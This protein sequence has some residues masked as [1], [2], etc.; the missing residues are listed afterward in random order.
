MANVNP[1]VQVKLFEDLGGGPLLREDI[2]PDIDFTDFI[3]SGN[4]W[5]SYPGLDPRDDQVINIDYALEQIS[6][7]IID[8]LPP[9]SSDINIVF[10]KIEYVL[11]VDVPIGTTL[12]STEYS[13]LND[14]LLVYWNG[15]LMQKDESYEFGDAAEDK[16]S[17]IRIK[18]NCFDGDEFTFITI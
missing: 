17:T 7:N 12:E 10:N 18:F 16:A 11:T 14:G 8:V 3:I 1:E 15:L 4:P 6:E 2:L 5:S 13:V 9:L